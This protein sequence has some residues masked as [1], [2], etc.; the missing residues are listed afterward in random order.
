MGFKS[1]FSLYTLSSGGH[2]RECLMKIKMFIE[3]GDSSH[4]RRIQITDAYMFFFISLHQK[5]I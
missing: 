4:T 5:Q 3:Y 1:F 2:V